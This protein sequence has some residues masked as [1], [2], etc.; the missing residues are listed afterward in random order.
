MLHYLKC[1]DCP[2]LL[3]LYLFRYHFCCFFI[4]FGT[5]SEY[6]TRMAGFPPSDELFKDKITYIRAAIIINMFNHFFQNNNK[7]GYAHDLCETTSTKG[8]E[9]GW[10]YVQLNHRYWSI[11]SHPYN[12]QENGKP[13]SNRLYADDPMQSMVDWDD[14]DDLR[15]GGLSAEF[16]MIHMMFSY[17]LETD[18]LIIE[19]P[20]QDLSKN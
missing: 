20:F 7:W 1:K 3:L 17:D 4:Y 8:L 13:S 10:Y 14:I 19:C 15:G 11:G 12:Y 9:K 18:N 6:R 16:C 5:I 2:E